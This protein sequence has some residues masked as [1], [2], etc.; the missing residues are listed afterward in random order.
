MQLTEQALRMEDAAQMLPPELCGLACALSVQEKEQVRE[1]RLRTGQPFAV[2]LGGR[3]LFV[4]RFGRLCGTPSGETVTVSARQTEDCFR[5]L[6]DYS[7]YS[8]QS[9]IAA[10]FITV[11]N[12]HRAG[13]CGSAVVEQGGVS[14]IRG[15]SS[16][17]LRVARQIHGAAD[18]LMRRVFGCGVLGALLCGIPGSGKTTLLRDAAR[19]L[20]ARGLR[21][22][23]VDERGELAA[24]YRG[25]AGNDL[26]PCSDIL[27]GYPKGD[28]ILRAVRCLAPDVV[29]CDEIG[30]E[31][32]ALALTE[33]VN[34][35]VAI[36]ATAHASDRTELMRKRGIM[37]LLVAGAFE[38]VVFLQDMR[39][40]CRIRE[41]VNARELCTQVGW[42]G[43]CDRNMLGGGLY[44]ARAAD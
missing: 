2:N 43:V 24:V 22:S 31:S 8:H 5:R 25:Q 21:V 29:I 26:G 6:C 23:V 1:L 10:G 19:Q 38:T 30:G 15:V 35:G 7:V 12:G 9:D 18:E 36:I 20:S 16:I 42:D 37:R 28:G 4:T 41:V 40:P 17:N 44:A 27:D 34:C 11:R 13:L 14:G 33:G 3:D 39:Q 32:E